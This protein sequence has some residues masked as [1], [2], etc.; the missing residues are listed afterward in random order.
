M[1]QSYFIPFKPECVFSVPN[2]NTVVQSARMPP[3]SVACRGSYRPL[4]GLQSGAGQYSPQIRAI[5]QKFSRAI[6]QP[7][8][9]LDSLVALV[10]QTNFVVQ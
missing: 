3:P 7:S 8:V 5:V 10:I 9:F 2:N 6:K 1:F 4:F